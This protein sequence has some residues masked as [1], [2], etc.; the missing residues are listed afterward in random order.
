MY[1]QLLR[2]KT[3]HKLKYFSKAMSLQLY[4]KQKKTCYQTILHQIRVMLE[5]VPK[6]FRCWQPPNF[7]AAM[8]ALQ[9]SCTHHHPL[10]LLSLECLGV[11]M[12]VG[13]QAWQA[14]ICPPTQVMNFVGPDPESIYPK[15]K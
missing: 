5:T 11:G 2:R 3:A 12:S 14:H 10:H 8:T 6:K 15:N 7:L 1:K 13:T 4:L 9:S